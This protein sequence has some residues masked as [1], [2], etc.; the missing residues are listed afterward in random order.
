MTPCP[1]DALSIQEALAACGFPSSVNP[2]RIGKD[3]GFTSRCYAIDLTGQTVVA[4]VTSSQHIH[5]RAEREAEVLKNFVVSARLPAPVYIGNHLCENS[6]EHVLFMSHVSG[7]EMK[8]FE[9][10]S[11]QVLI[12]ALR[13]MIPCW[14]TH[15]EQLPSSSL[16][17]EWGTGTHGHAKPHTRRIRRF[18]TRSENFM[19]YHLHHESSAP[20]IPEVLNWIGEHLEACLEKSAQWPSALI[21]GDLHPE[22]IIIRPKDV[23][24]LDWQTAS[25]GSPLLDITRLLMDGAPDLEADECIHLTETIAKEY[26]DLGGKS[27]STL[28]C[29]ENCAIASILA[30]AGFISGWGGKSKSQLS[31][32]EYRLVQHHSSVNGPTRL[33]NELIRHIRV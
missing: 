32:R 15:I 20:E 11:N 5:P 8:T 2:V 24:I 31:S 12:Q 27:P 9:R 6:K 17:S 21:H 10:E 25:L 3:R 13:S 4:K 23:S 28:R 16:I 19:Q 33:A 1:H 26:E 29:T 7:N 14:A 30:Y 18:R 22:N